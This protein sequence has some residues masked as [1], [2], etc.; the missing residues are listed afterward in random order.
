MRVRGDEMSEEVDWAS[1]PAW[2]VL[3]GRCQH[4]L[5]KGSG[6][7]VRLHLQ[8]GVYQPQHAERG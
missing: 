4:L 3:T 1:N 7:R 6:K 5:G 8:R 2:L